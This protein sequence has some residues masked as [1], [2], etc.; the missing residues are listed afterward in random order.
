MTRT[1]LPAAMAVL[2]ACLAPALAAQD[3]SSRAHAPQPTV[4]GITEAD[5]RTRLFIFADDS[6]QGREAG[7]EGHL[8]STDYLAAE[9]R[10]LGLEPAGD[11]GTYFQTVPLARR[12]LD[13]ASSVSVAGRSLAF[14]TDVV[15]VRG[16]VATEVTPVFAGSLHD[17]SG[18]IGR[19]AVRGRLVVFHATRVVAVPRRGRSQCPAVAQ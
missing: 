14:W 2:L 12:A 8:R 19:E 6:M 18:W 5:L 1:F 3:D 4:P 9:L 17:S 10:A 16:G 11:S 13:E 15:P 7:T